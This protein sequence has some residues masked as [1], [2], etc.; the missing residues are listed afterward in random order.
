MPVLLIAEREFRT[1]VAT[2]SF[3][4]SLAVAPVLAGAALLFSGGGPVQPLL[5]S[6]QGGNAQLVQSASLAL[7]EASR[8]EGKSIVIGQGGATLT[9]AQPAPHTLE[10]S[11]SDGFPLSPV[12][13]AMVDHVIERDMARSQLRNQEMRGAAAASFVAVR[14]KQADAGPAGMDVAHLSR[15]ATMIMLWLTLTGSL[16]MLLQAVARERANRALESL[17]ASARGWEIV[18]GK[19]LGVGAVSLLILIAWLG[20]A[21]FFS[22]FSTPGA[23]LIPAVLADFA[24]PLTLLRDALIYVCAFGFYGA[25]T[26]VLGAMARDSASAQ[27]VARPLFLLL[28]AAFFIALVTPAG[29]PSWLTYIPPLTPFLL[30]VNSAGSVAVMSQAILL[31]ILIAAS[32]AMMLLAARLL[33]VAPQS[34]YIFKTSPTKTQPVV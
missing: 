20:S 5:V 23:G 16:G 17:L 6:I 26:L 22:A 2:L 1:Y 24:R 28:L 34:Y 29:A 30:L 12:A 33:S 18:A 13:R 10:T 25:A 32:G 11:F 7:E 31:A 3:W 27:N 14:E 8:L 21:A 19:L 15:L 9:L 4:L